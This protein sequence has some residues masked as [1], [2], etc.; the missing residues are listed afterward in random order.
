MNND[1]NHLDLLDIK[2]PL[3][4]DPGDGTGPLWWVLVVLYRRRRPT[5]VGFRR[6]I[7]PHAAGA[8]CRSP[9]QTPRSLG[10]ARH[11]R[12]L[13]RSR[14]RYPACVFGGTFQGHAPNAPPKSFSMNC[15]KCRR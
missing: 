10:A 15:N 2:P 12:P 5:L 4:L 7:S 11:A 6:P 14:G 1:T 8:R 13:Y 9:T 3:D